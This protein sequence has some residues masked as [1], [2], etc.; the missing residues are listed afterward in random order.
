MTESKEFSAPWGTLLKVIS[1]TMTFLLVA[2]F[3]GM[4]LSGRASSIVH[5]LLYLLI[6]LLIILVG[7]LFTVRGYELEGS[8]LK[9][10]RLLW[11][12]VIDLGVVEGV[13]IDPKAMTGAI[14]TWGNGGLYSFSG[15]F[16]S[17]RF[18]GFRAY[19]TDFRNCVV[20]R[21]LSGIL[22]VSPGDPERFVDLL[23]SRLWHG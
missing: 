10:R 5:I 2:V 12:T 1:S 17:T 21:T 3:G 19:V 6:P 15:R 13:E 20:I 22:V 7:M 8:R 14:R 23:K 18:G 11:S 4:A 16:R 9:I